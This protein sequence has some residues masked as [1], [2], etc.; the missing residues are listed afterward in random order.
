MSRIHRAIIALSLALAANLCL[1][2]PPEIVKPEI[3]SV[4]KIWDQGKHNAFTDLI[5]WRGKWYCSFRESEGHVGGDGN[6]RVLVSDDGQKWE[7]AA[8]I[9]ELGIDLRD[10]KLSIT[11]DDRLMIVAGGS[12]YGGTKVLK[13]RQPR[14]CFSK[15]G[16]EW[17][18]P[19]KTLE[20]G[21]WLWRDN[22]RLNDKIGCDMVVDHLRAY[23]TTE[24]SPCN[25]ACMVCGDSAPKV[26]TM[27]LSD[28]VK[29]LSNLIQQALGRAPST[30][31][32]APIGMA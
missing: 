8:L 13:T 18:A 10:P 14:V 6:L 30:K 1:S 29:T 12:V 3:I 22:V 9:S 31:S 11:S 20:D 28:R 27:L 15:D 4:T 32:V 26:L 24:H 2:A 16:R 19:Q 25:T 17:T 5:R 7:S 23:P 21:D